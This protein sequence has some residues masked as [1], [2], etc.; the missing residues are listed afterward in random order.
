MHI[1][2]QY[3]LLVFICQLFFHFYANLLKQQQLFYKIVSLLKLKKPISAI[4]FLLIYFIVKNLK[5]INITVKNKM[6]TVCI[7]FHFTQENLYYYTE[8]L[9]E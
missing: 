8:L 2:I 7:S 3:T 9:T 4:L 1:F 6:Y 5:H